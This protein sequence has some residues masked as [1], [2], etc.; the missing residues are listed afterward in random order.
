VNL[1]LE[2]E[3]K[4]TLRTVASKTPADFIGSVLGESEK[5]TK[6]IIK[7]TQGK[8]LLIDEAYGLYP[9][10]NSA[11]STADPYKTGV[12]DTIVADV[13]STPGEDQCV[14]L[15]GYKDQMTEMMENSNPGLSRRFPLS[16]AFHFDDFND[17]ELKQILEL[18]L[19][20]QGLGATEEAKSVAIE[21]LRRA[22]DRPNFGNA[23]E[24][25]NLI[26]RAKQ[27][28]QNRSL[29]M[30]LDGPVS[31]ILFLPQDFDEDFDRATKPADSCQ[32]LF[33]DIVGC[34]ELINRL[35]RY[36]RIVANMTAM[37]RDPRDQIPF[38]FIFKGP[39]GEQKWSNTLGHT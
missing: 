31:D 12:I 18:K 27:G 32:S 5:N 17:E 20:K 25:E 29:S 14:L 3:S 28:E 8:V 2:M 4:L 33:A 22:R 19:E 1:G 23:G 37:N 24:V 26:S 6:G 35:E 9:G 13:Q 11:G 10:A 39:P 30:D 21:V 15:L 16:D 36:Q 7:S 34:E 38:N